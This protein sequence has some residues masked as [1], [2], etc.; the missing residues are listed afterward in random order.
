V[1]EVA[2]IEQPAGSG[3]T[4][5]PTMTELADRAPAR[6]IVVR[7]RTLLVVLGTL[8]LVGAGLWIL[9]NARQVLGWMVIALFLAMALNPAVEFFVRLGL[10]RGLSVALV[11][12]LTALGLAGLGYLFIPPLI[13]QTRELI[14][15]IPGVVDDLT[16]GRGPL[17]FLER[18]YHVVDRVREALKGQGAE[19]ILGLTSPAIDVV[20]GVVTGI[21]AAVTIF[22]L[23]VF[24]LLEG[25]RWVAR[26]LDLVPVRVRPRWER[27]GH[28]VYRTVGGYVTGNLLISLIAGLCAFVILLGTGVSFAVPLAVL[29][30]VTDLIPLVGATIGTVVVALVAYADRGLVTALIVVGALIVYQ[31]LENHFL[32]PVIYG[33]TVQLSPLTILVAVLIGAEIAGLLGA[34]IAIPVGG[35]IQVVLGEIMDARR[36][37]ALAL[38]P[39]AARS[40]PGE[41]G[42]RASGD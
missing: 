39:G 22:F 26:G 2:T 16:R 17:G 23:T 35:A 30:A 10:R 11:C 27:A 40:E 24:M 32:Q 42:A 12:V 31:Q 20:R 28:G 7:P 34:L 19:R 33:R 14:E 18:D 13:D 38:P 6:E 5:P 1:G 37:R 3:P 8:L 25:P 4:E 29:I 21:A 15:A 41:G 36:Q 9:L